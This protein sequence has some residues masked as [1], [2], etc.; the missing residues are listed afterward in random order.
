MHLRTGEHTKLE[1]SFAKAFSFSRRAETRKRKERE[2]KRN[3]N[4]RISAT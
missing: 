4:A 1:N 3:P 2:Q